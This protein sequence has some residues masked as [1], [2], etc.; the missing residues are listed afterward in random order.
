M[1]DTVVVEATPVLVIVN[2]AELCPDATV[3]LVGTEVAE[4]LSCRVT[5]APPGG[6][7]PLRVTVPVELVPPVT[8]DGF[9]LRPVSTAGFT[10][11]VAEA[12]AL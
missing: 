5:D 4:L 1:I 12:V 8:V 3:T 10:V 11:I 6:A 9:R 7:A 2:V